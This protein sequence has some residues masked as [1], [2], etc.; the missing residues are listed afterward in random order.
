ML[1]TSIGYDFRLPKVKTKEDNP[2][3]FY[4]M[5]SRITS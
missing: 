5:Y 1:V 4:D 2:M 3:I